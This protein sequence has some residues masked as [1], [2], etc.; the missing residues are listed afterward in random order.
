[1]GKNRDRESLIRFIVITI[2]HEIVLANT[3]RQESEH[4][5]NSEVIEY[6]SQTEKSADNYN[7]NNE[8]RKYIE[9]KALKMIKERL[10][11]KYSDVSYSEQELKSLLNEFIEEML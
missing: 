4:F 5:L 3:N 11:V 2:V 1:M 9:E 7:W 10:A 8:D 6:R